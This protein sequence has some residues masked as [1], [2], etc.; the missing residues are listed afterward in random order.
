MFTDKESPVV[1]SDLTVIHR[2]V[3]PDDTPTQ[4]FWDTPDVTDNSRH[5][6]N[7][8]SNK[9]PGDLF[10]TGMTTVTYY[11]TDE[12][13]NSAEFSFDILIMGKIQFWHEERNDLFRNL[14]R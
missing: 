12:F 14:Q 11:A 1:T 4:V 5:P 9:Q 3:N 7:I 13:G 6:V 8:I 10:P 2:E